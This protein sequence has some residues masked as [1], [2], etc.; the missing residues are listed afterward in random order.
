MSML[1]LLRHGQS[2]W[3]LENR[4][5]GWT[6]VGLT[7]AGRADAVLAGKS[8][9]DVHFDVV[10]VS[11]LKR[12]VDTY[13]AFVEGHG[14]SPISPVADSALNERHYGDL[15]GLNKGETIKKFGEEQV[16]LWRRS[17]STRPPGG[18]SIED[19]ERRTWP[20][21]KEYVLPLLAAGKNVLIVAHGN[22]L[23]PIIKNLDGM[24]PN[25]AAV[26]EIFCSVPYVYT[27]AGERVTEK[28]VREVPGMVVKGTVLK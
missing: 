19:C 24:Q 21:F 7:S 26:M 28:E 3:N 4:F 17:Y 22:S 1:V 23:R 14:Q 15:Q 9:K 11:R 2:Q 16:K 20:F 12:S 10:F 5:T 6:D 18:E 27:F 13:T 25:E 8:M